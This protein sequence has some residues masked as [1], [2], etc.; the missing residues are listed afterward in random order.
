MRQHGG[1]FSLSLIIGQYRVKVKLHTDG[2]TT[3]HQ[4][5]LQ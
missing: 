2:C 3:Q 1:E 4:L 5:Q